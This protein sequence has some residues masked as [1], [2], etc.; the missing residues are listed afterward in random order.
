MND[1]L[2]S[3]GLPTGVAAG[4]RQLHGFIREGEAL[5]D[6]SDFHHHGRWRPDLAATAAGDIA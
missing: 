1:A 5:A 4:R 6:A 2:S 3:D